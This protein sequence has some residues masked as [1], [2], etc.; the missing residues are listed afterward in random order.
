[1]HAMQG[2]YHAHHRAY[3]M[4]GLAVVLG[5]AAVVGLAILVSTAV[6]PTG[7]SSVDPPAVPLPAHTWFGGILE[8]NLVGVETLPTTALRKVF[9]PSELQA[10]ATART[11]A[12]ALAQSRAAETLF[13][14]QIR[15]FKSNPWTAALTQSRADES[16]LDR[17]LRTIKS[18]AGVVIPSTPSNTRYDGKAF[19]D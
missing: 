12:A 19:P 10:I 3:D 4:A 15:V 11:Q 18:N 5:L 13:D 7:G 8:E 17:Q 14:R 9:A 6:R 2:S 1:M 16:N